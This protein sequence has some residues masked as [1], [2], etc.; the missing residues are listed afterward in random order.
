MGT[1]IKDRLGYP[2]LHLDASPGNC[3]NCGKCD[4]SCPM[5]LPVS[6]MVAGGKMKDTECIMCAS[7]VD[8]CPAKAIK[9]AWL[10]HDETAAEPE[11][12]A[13]VPEKARLSA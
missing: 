8:N 4:R 10:H 2:S 12:T 5:S 9:Y 7:C 6:K 13:D 3:K 11:L 1:K